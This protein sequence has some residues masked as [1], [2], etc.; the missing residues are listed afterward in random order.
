M[1]PQT[2]QLA[3]GAIEYLEISGIPSAAPLVF[4]HEGL[5]SLS[6]WRG[7][8]TELCAATGRRGLVF[9]RHG[10]GG[11]EVLRAPRESEYM[12]R[13]AWE[14][15]PVV[16]ENLDYLR[17]VLVG[18]SDGASIALI[19]AGSGIGQPAALVLLAPHVIVED[20]TIAGIETAREAFLTTDLPE[21]L[22]RHHTDPA[23]TF[24]GWNDVWLSPEFRR[25]DIRDILDGVTCPVLAIQCVDDPYGS[26]AQ[27]DLVTAGVTGPTRRLVLPG[28]GHAPHQE[29]PEETIAAIAAFLA[30]IEDP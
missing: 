9:S 1:S 22:A 19:Y 24:W 30:E 27:L 4:L 29:H 16:L 25:W 14:V 5:G 26:L 12:H 21:R 8:P 11:S 15:L 7:F 2:I 13:E 28:A 3:R 10:Y 6:T 23:S 20:R 17:P 18:H